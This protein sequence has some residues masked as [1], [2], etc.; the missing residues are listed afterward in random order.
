MEKPKNSIYYISISLRS[1][2]G[3]KPD[4][5][6]SA[7]DAVFDLVRRASLEDRIAWAERLYS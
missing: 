2:V 7:F 4:C 6:I 1:K 5:S 3:I